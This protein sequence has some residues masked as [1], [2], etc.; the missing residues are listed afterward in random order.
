MSDREMLDWYEQCWRAAVGSCLQW[1]APR[2]EA[3]ILRIEARTD[4]EFILHELPMWY[5]S[6]LLLP[7]EIAGVEGLRMRRLLQKHLESDKALA[8][9]CERV[10]IDAASLV[11]RIDAVLRNHGSS[12]S[13]IQR[14]LEVN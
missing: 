4:P 9:P 1:D 6:V 12:L 2:I 13:A 10:K 5:V 14:T 3:W 11:E 8:E 7:S